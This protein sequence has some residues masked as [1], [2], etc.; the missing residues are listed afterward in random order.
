MVEDG[1]MVEMNYLKMILEGNIPYNRIE[2]DV[3]GLTKVFPRKPT[4]HSNH[5]SLN[6]KNFCRLDSLFM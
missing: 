1:E 3:P 4:T 5:S 6:L 2:D